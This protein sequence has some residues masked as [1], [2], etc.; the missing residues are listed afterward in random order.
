MVSYGNA[1]LHLSVGKRNGPIGGKYDALMDHVVIGKQ[2]AVDG[3]N[4]Q[5]VDV[6]SPIFLH[7]TSYVEWKSYLSD[8]NTDGS[9][10]SWS[11]ALRPG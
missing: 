4:V 7:F 1:R 8:V 6:R 11:F 2:N 10:Y 5:E 9:V 3:T